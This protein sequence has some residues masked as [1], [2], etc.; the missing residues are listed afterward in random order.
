MVLSAVVFVLGSDRQRC[1]DD[2]AQDDSRDQAPLGA[3]RGE[4][5]GHDRLMLVLPILPFYATDLGA[6][7]VTIGWLIG[8]F[9]IAQLIAAPVWGRVS[10]RY[11]SADPRS[12]SDS[13]LRD[14]VL[15]FGLATTV[16]LLFLSRLIQGAGGG[17]RVWRR[18]RG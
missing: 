3:D 14:C 9:S 2:R 12:S 5:R 18:P 11:G 8:A 4:F 10:D 16:W 7:P 1:R 6:S 17:T 13:P 15:V